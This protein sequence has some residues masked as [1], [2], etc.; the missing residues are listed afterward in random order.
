MAVCVTI[1]H[2]FVKSYMASNS[3]AS[4]RIFKMLL[5][6]CLMLALYYIF[7]QFSWVVKVKDA[8]V[9]RS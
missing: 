1:F 2:G 9:L 5:D 3:E 7:L 4:S 8:E 6:K